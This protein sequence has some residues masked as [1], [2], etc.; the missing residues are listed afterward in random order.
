MS[1]KIS[2][3]ICRGMATSAI[4]E[5]DIAANH[6]Q[7]IVEIVGERMKLKPQGVG[8]RRPARQPHPV[9]SIGRAFAF[10][11]PLLDVPRLL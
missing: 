11:D 7:E 10:R 3:N 5:G 9:A 8:R 2:G 6:P 1:R 4:L